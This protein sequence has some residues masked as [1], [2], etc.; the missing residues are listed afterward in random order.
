VTRG[1]TTHVISGT[2][3]AVVIPS[4]TGSGSFSSSGP[5]IATMAV[6]SGKIVIHVRSAIL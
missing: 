2:A 4:L 1:I 6:M 5:V 3:I